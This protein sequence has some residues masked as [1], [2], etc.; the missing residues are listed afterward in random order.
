MDPEE[1]KYETYRKA[2]SAELHSLD[3]SSSITSPIIYYLFYKPFR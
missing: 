3:F 2:E 1:L